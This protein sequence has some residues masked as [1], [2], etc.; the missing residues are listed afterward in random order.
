MGITLDIDGQLEVG[1]VISKR[2]KAKAVLWKCSAS[3]AWLTG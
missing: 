3:N 2:E 1:M